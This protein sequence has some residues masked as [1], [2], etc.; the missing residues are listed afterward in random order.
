MHGIESVEVEP[1]R[2]P[3]PA[4]L[5]LARDEARD[6]RGRRRAPYRRLAGRLGFDPLA[7]GAALRARL[8]DRPLGDDA[9]IL[10]V[11]LALDARE[12]AAIRRGVRQRALALHVF[13]GELLARGGGVAGCVD[14][15]VLERVVAAERDEL[16][17]APAG[18]EV[19]F[20]YGP[21]IARGPDGGWVVI[22]DNVGCVGGIADG[23]FVG[24]AYAR[25]AG[26][27]ASEPASADLVLAL[28]R[29]RALLGDPPDGWLAATRGC[30][31]GDAAVR[32]EEDRRRAELLG[33]AGARMLDGACL[34][35]PGTD[36]GPPA[37]VANS[38]ALPPTAIANSGALPPAAIAN[39]GAPPPTAIANLGALP[40]TAIANSGAPP[41]TA[42]AN[43]GALPPTAI[44]NSGAPPPTAI[45]NF[46]A[47]P[48]PS[49]GAAPRLLNS[50]GT[51]LLGDKALLPYVDEMIRRASGE[52]PLL[53]S[54]PTRRPA[55]RCAARAA[56][57]LGRQ[58]RDRLRRRRRARAR[59]PRRRRR[60]SSEHARRRPVRDRRA[61]L[62]RLLDAA[63]DGPS[64]IEL[65]P[66]AYVL[67]RDEVFV[68]EQ[69]VGK[70]VPAADRRA[71][72]NVSRGAR[73]VAVLVAENG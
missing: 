51:G 7:P 29:W 40:P 5:P 46:G 37:A 59:H 69:L 49:P 39:L 10:P 42:I 24:R 36:P 71:L 19:A 21:D 27:P 67:G 33:L 2:H 31:P 35:S 16:Q 1:Q 30:G 41:P 6:A 32:I 55:R 12:H 23:W 18:D 60:G 56:G 13:F 62:D 65:R 34:P 58:D 44:A 66:I 61:A 11:P 70:A 28:A 14:A 15:D 72:N 50:P 47:L 52:E 57:G 22:E 45:A 48:P 63:L 43:L 26:L 4:G 54:A 20:V 9:R 38:G 8:D 68:G 17:R 3:C 64:R 25:A 73:Y 53:R